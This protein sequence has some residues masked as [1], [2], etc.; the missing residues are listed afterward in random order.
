M[1]PEGSFGK[2]CASKWERKR[3]ALRAG[4]YTLLVVVT[5]TEV[6]EAV[7]V[8]RATGQG[9]GVGVGVVTL[10][11]GRGTVASYAR[12]ARVARVTRA[13]ARVAHFRGASLTGTELCNDREVPSAIWIYLRRSQTV[14]T[15]QKVL[16]F[17]R[18]SNASSRVILDGFSCFYGIQKLRELFE[19]ASS[20]FLA[21]IS[22]KDFL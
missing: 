6:A 16:I 15:H 2:V 17:L 21:P 9:T 1:E 4:R 5:Q 14:P 7:T 13:A 11:T 8:L 10:V 20:F 12:I 18:P 3:R 22:R 19:T